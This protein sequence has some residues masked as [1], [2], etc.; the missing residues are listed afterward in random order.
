MSIAPDLRVLEELSRKDC[1]TEAESSAL[2]RVLDHITRMD[3]GIAQMKEAIAYFEAITTGAEQKRINDIMLDDEIALAVLDG[4][5]SAA[6]VARHFG[7]SREKVIR[8]VRDKAMSHERYNYDEFLEQLRDPS[9]GILQTS[10][11]MWKKWN[12][13]T[14]GAEQKNA[15][16]ITLRDEI[17]LCVLDD[18]ENATKV[19]RRFGCSRHNVLQCVDEQLQ[20]HERYDSQEYLDQLRVIGSGRLTTATTLWKRWNEA[21]LVD[22]STRIR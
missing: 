18:G 2:R 11:I 5:E 22:G 3:K 16:V 12:S 14:T 9:T 15:E 7:C 20:K 8:L 21:L 19:A 13:I 1:L 17:A 4:G 6:G 10:I